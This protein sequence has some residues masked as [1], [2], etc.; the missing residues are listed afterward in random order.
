MIDDEAFEFVQPKPTNQRPL[1]GQSILIVEDSRTASEALRIIC[2]RSGARVRRADSLASA[3]RHL[4]VFTPTV[5]IVDITLPDGSGLD[6]IAEQ[7]VRIVA[8]PVSIAI[9]GDS[10]QAKAALSAGAMAFVA[11]PIVSMAQFQSLLV[12][13]LPAL[14]D[15]NALRAEPT[16]SVEI[17]QNSMLA[18]LRAAAK[19]LRERNSSQAR[20]GYVSKFVGEIANQ[21]KDQ[22]LADVARD[23]QR[24]GVGAGHRKRLLTMVDEKLGA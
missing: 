9:S 7:A 10:L 22:S 20:A 23:L 18:D 11:K 12:S 2:C 5:L 6:L 19:L 21:T 24:D 3:R 8:P 14:K 1:T 13:T 17:D 4:S 15:L 16:K